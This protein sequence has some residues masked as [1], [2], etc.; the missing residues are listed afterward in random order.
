[1]DNLNNKK[2]LKIK[3]LKTITDN[4]NW[5][6]YEDSLFMSKVFEII[7]K[8]KNYLKIINKYGL[9]YYID[10]YKFF[11]KLSYKKNSINCLDYFHGEPKD[12][13][14]FRNFYNKLKKCSKNLSLIRVPNEKLYNSMCDYGINFEG[15]ISIIPIPVNS[16]IFSKNNIFYRNKI[17]TELKIPNSIFLI[18]SFQKD[19]IGWGKGDLPK[20][21]KG[22]DIF[23]K[24][25]ESL[26]SI[27]KKYKKSLGVLLSGPSRGYIKKGLEKLDVKYWHK[28][29][30]DLNEVSELYA[31][32]DAYFISSR[33]EGGP[34]S[35]LESISSKVPIVSTP[36]GQVVDL[37]NESELLGKTFCPDEYGNLL[38]DLI[39]NYQKHYKKCKY[40]YNKLVDFYS[41]NKQAIIWEYKLKSRILNHIR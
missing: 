18:G 37:Y 39:E 8:D 32:I 14:I 41:F 13:K 16:K 33:L 17:R 27:N 25:I 2:L 6:F 26:I 3:N 21:E 23:L 38:N 34:K 1:M 15:N 19:G 35:F 5:S 20:L 12:G 24:S 9:H 28:Y 4:A 29:C 10:R 30:N 36:V 7:I 31:G 40:F 22:P 11:S